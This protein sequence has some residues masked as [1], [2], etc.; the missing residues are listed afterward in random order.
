V[1]VY[2]AFEKALVTLVFSVNS[3]CFRRQELVC[4]CCAGSEGSLE[5]VASSRL[6]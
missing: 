3:S 4:D 2:E 1:V 5:P 6:W